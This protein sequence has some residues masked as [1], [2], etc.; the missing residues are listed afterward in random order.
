MNGT[1]AV[2]SNRTTKFYVVVVVIS[3][4]SYD[5]NGKVFNLNGAS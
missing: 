4:V 5:N 3:V 1:L 2:I